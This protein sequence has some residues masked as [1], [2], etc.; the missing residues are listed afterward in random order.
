MTTD[1]PPC[2]PPTTRKLHVN[3]TN[4]AENFS[5]PVVTTGQL[6]CSSIT[7]PG[8]P[9]SDS[10]ASADPAHDPPLADSGI[11]WN[12]ATSDAI[13]VDEANNVWNSGHISDILKRGPNEALVASDTGGVWSVAWSSNTA[14]ALPL[15]T[16]WNS[17]IITSLAQ[18]PDGTDHVYAGTATTAASG[19]VSGPPG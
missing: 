19:G 1:F 8:P 18:G 15:S 17:I 16:N 9:G 3:Q 7:G 13:L 2:V 5:L 14:G 4:V 10:D 11:Q 12:I 6:R